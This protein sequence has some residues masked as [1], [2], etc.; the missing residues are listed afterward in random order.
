MERVIMRQSAALPEG[1]G[2]PRQGKRQGDVTEERLKK[3]CA[4]FEAIFISYMLKTMRNTV[5]KSGLNE[6][7]G[8][9]TYT[10]LMDQKVAEDLANRG[11][12]MGIQ[13]MLLHQ[14]RG[15]RPSDDAGE[16]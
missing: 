14:F 2:A 9:D 5:P 7:P 3:A 12:G 4:D 16:R 1:S 10:M 13:K 6:F 15:L 8:K 11:R